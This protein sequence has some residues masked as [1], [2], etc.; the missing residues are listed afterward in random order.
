[1][2]EKPEP[3][4]LTIE[5]LAY[6]GKGVARLNGLV[7]FVEATAPGDRVRARIVKRKQGYAEAVATE[8]IQPSPH[9]VEPSC[10]HFGDCG[11]C[12]ALHLAYDEQ[13]RQKADQV[14]ETLARI[15]RQGDLPI[16]P[17]QPSPVLWR[18]R[19]KMDF[20][21]GTDAD[22]RL[23]LG[24][25]RRGQFAGIVNIEQCRLQP[26][27]F[28]RALAIVREFARQSMLPAYSQRRHEG[29]WRHLILR[30]SAAENRML[31]VLITASGELPGVERLAEELEAAD[32]GL[33][34]FVWAV[35]DS[36][37]DVAAVKEKR[38]EW[39]ADSL[40]ER[41]G[42]L[43]YRISAM[44]FFQVNPAATRALYD[45]VVEF[46]EP[47][48]AVTVLDAYCGTG[49]IGI[50]CARHFGRVIGI[51]SQ[52]EAVWDARQNAALND[53]GNCTFLCGPVNRMVA[54]A[55]SHAAGRFG[56]VIVDPPRGGMDKHAL[57]QLLELRAPVFLYVSCNPAT[58][59]R[60]VVAATDA[61][62]RIERVRPFDL[63]PH[64]PHIETVIK[65]VL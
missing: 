36:V 10:V 30:H 38:F 35:N 15:G 23:V 9:R 24:L 64:T 2:A 40:H 45:C 59:A 20:T 53:L 55:K 56:R 28:D 32:I 11:G 43:T 6:G 37:A 50:Y 60:D 57:A 8:I 29:F 21:F 52:R 51:E 34:G 17:I 62:Y 4:E 47:N 16:E 13:L 42:D 22:G 44:S 41:L 3:V 26:E 25:H 18:Y 63:F 7:V 14:R 12:S 31:A 46:I 5:R 49:S 19:N 54:L 61:G 27:S 39:G 48:P 33:A 1:M 58:L 65:F